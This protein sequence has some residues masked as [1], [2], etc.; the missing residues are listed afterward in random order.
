MPNRRA[1]DACQNEESGL[2]LRL[3]VRG[4]RDQSWRTHA[5]LGVLAP[6]VRLT[7]HP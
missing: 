2:N 5:S 1:V 3:S 7:T 4:D 6:V